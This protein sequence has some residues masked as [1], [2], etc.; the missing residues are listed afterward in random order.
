MD[1][2]ARCEACRAARKRRY[3]LNAFTEFVLCICLRIARRIFFAAKKNPVAVRMARLHFLR[4][5]AQEIVLSLWMAL[6]AGVT[7][8]ATVC[9]FIAPDQCG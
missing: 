5:A 7:P 9:P 4:R 1:A 3:E 6:H 2:A 8:C